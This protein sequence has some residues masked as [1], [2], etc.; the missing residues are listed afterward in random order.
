MLNRWR[1]LAITLDVQCLLSQP[2]PHAAMVDCLEEMCVG[3]SLNPN[4]RDGRF[5]GVEAS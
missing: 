4:V 1:L 5:V 3:V 2:A